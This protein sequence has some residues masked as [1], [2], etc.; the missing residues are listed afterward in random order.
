[1]WPWRENSSAAG[2]SPMSVIDHG[3]E[4]EGRLTFGGTLILN[5][6][7]KGEV[8]SSD[9]LIVGEAG[10]LQADVRV[11]VAIVSGQISGQ[12]TARERVELRGNAQIRGDIVTPMLVLE[13]GVIFNG[14][15]KMK[16]EELQVAHRTS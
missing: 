6:K 15:C 14:H 4:I 12:I 3:C 7:F 9:T 10:D 16:G 1:M 5:G 2:H 13:K 11:G 8:V